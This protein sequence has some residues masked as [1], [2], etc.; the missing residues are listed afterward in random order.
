MKIKDIN[1]KVIKKFIITSK[2]SK[3]RPIIWDDEAEINALSSATMNYPNGLTLLNAIFVYDDFNEG[4]KLLDLGAD[5]TAGV[6]VKSDGSLIGD[7]ALFALIINNSFGNSLKDQIKSIADRLYQK[8]SRLTSNEVEL[9]LKTADLQFL[10]FLPYLEQ[11]QIDK[12]LSKFYL[13]SNKNFACAEKNI[14]ILL[15][16]L[17]EGKFELF[18]KLIEAAPAVFTK[19]ALVSQ[20]KIL[21]DAIFEHAGE[22][23]M[24]HVG[25]ESVNNFFKQYDSKKVKEFVNKKIKGK[26]LIETAIERGDR[27]QFTL[28][29]ELGA[30]L[31]ILK[32]INYQLGFRMVSDKPWV[33]I[34]REMN[35]PKEQLTQIMDDN[36]DQLSMQG[37]TPLAAAVSNGNFLNTETVTRGK[38]Q[39]PDRLGL[40]AAMWAI[41]Y[42]EE[43][44]WLNARNETF[45]KKLSDK[46]F[47]LNAWDIYGNT[48]FTL[49]AQ[50]NLQ[51]PSYM[52]IETL[53]NL[54]VDINKVNREGD[55][56]L[57]IAIKNNDVDL[58]KLFINNRVKNKLH[59][60]LEDG[61]GRIPFQ[62]AI[63]Y[64]NPETLKIVKEATLDELG[65]YLKKLIEEGETDKVNE[66]LKMVLSLAEYSETELNQLALTESIKNIVQTLQKET[67]AKKDKSL[68]A[69]MATFVSKIKPGVSC[70]SLTDPNDFVT[71]ILKQ[72]ERSLLFESY[73]KKNSN[74]TYLNFMNAKIMITI[75]QF[76]DLY[77]KNN[78]QAEILFSQ[79]KLS[80]I[81][82]ISIIMQKYQNSAVL[83]S[84]LGKVM[85]GENWLNKLYSEIKD[86]PSVLNAVAKKFTF[87][88]MWG[89]AILWEAIKD[90]N[91]D[92]VKKCVGGKKML[93]IQ[94]TNCPVR[95]AISQNR[96]DILEY[97]LAEGADPFY[98]CN[99]TAK[100]TLLQ[101]VN[102]DEQKAIIEKYIKLKELDQKTSTVN[103]LKPKSVV[104]IDT[105]PIKKT[106]LPVDDITDIAKR[107]A[108][109]LGMK[110]VKLRLPSGEGVIT[111]MEVSLQGTTSIKGFNWVV[112]SLEQHLQK[113]L[114]NNDLRLITETYQATQEFLQGKK[115]R[116]SLW[117]R[118]QSGKPV[119]LATDFAGHGFAM[120]LQD[121]FL[122]VSNRGAEGDQKYG[123]KIYE[124]LPGANVEY[125]IKTA[126]ILYDYALTQGFCTENQ[127][128][129]FHKY[130]LNN[131]VDVNAPFDQLDQKGQKRGNCGVAN[132]K[133]A[134]Q[135]M[136]YI[137]LL[138]R[139]KDRGENIQKKKA[140]FRDR[141]K[142]FYKAHSDVSREFEIDSLQRDIQEQR[143]KNVN[144]DF[145]YQVL[146]SFI[147]EHRDFNAKDGREGRRIGRVWEILPETYQ[148]RILKEFPDFK[149]MQQEFLDKQQT[150]VLAR[151][152]VLSKSEDLS[153]ERARQRSER[154]K[155]QIADDKNENKDK[156]E[157]VGTEK[158]RS[159]L[160][161]GKLDKKDDVLMGSKGSKALP[162][163]KI[164]DPNKTKRF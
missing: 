25:K 138:H 41:H 34:C 151:E 144:E 91:F 58:L 4:T 45:F 26:F 93:N 156:K 152:Q 164:K 117:Q 47:D 139:A 54:G 37:L 46:G 109:I 105:H 118:Y 112:N 98:G 106:N 62:I 23:L 116:E 20:N 19:V 107:S 59:L 39:D 96:N 129:Q 149:K 161:S 134:V 8:G 36:F 95:L 2:T 113:D 66:Y 131:I 22:E 14:D 12:F 82:V 126:S 42:M 67:E 135:G 89:Q 57:V 38:L 76:I 121:G 75:K 159:M 65:N 83:L 10:D 11:S 81:S 43:F 120:I 147:L 92:F 123:T 50:R 64:G 68:A 78:E 13:E 86:Y 28:L 136:Q 21:K 69:D 145:Y 137:N 6:V 30:D 140:D 143:A 1:E 132:R 108:H 160:F 124:I 101:L 55:S 114:S 100:E 5:P 150:K 87:K 99:F 79:R 9:L 77:N 141:S 70:F 97:L 163:D 49:C 16:L 31:K 119:V 52:A 51:R 88:E 122:S 157:R 155:P 24:I 17:K 102:N 133:A 74:I 73:L 162:K 33:G 80:I 158:S 29:L 130:L 63:L 53:M 128:V 154:E 90:N 44:G 27:S 3:H 32:N 84:L 40:N 153:L 103:V 18:R 48:L 7:S 125:F 127:T 94:L 110:N 146:E 148:N 56:P 72:P 115:D 60:L 15:G 71:H 61:Q 35:L 104:D 85:L 142:R 111:E